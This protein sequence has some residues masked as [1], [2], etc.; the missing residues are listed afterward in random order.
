MGEFKE[1]KIK[2]VVKS[3]KCCSYKPGD[4]IYIERSIVD[5]EKSANICLTALTAIYPFIYAA[6]K[7]VTLEQMGFSEMCFQ[8]PDIDETVRFEI[9]QYEEEPALFEQ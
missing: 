9:I 6:R 5:K 8:C 3:S 4:A 7:H 2:L 1:K